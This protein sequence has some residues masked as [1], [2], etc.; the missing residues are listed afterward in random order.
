MRLLLP[1]VS[2]WS[3]FDYFSQPT[4]CCWQPCMRANCAQ[5][6]GKAP[7]GDH[8]GFLPW[9]LSPR[10]LPS[11][12]TEDTRKCIMILWPCNKECCCS[13][14]V[15]MPT[16]TDTRAYLRKHALYILHLAVAC[17]SD[18]RLDCSW[19]LTCSLCSVRSDFILGNM[20]WALERVH[21][22]GKEALHTVDLH[23]SVWPW[24]FS[25]SQL[26]APFAAWSTLPWISTF[27]PSIG[28]FHPGT[29]P[30]WSPSSL[31][32]V[33]SNRWKE[34]SPKKCIKGLWAQAQCKRWWRQ[35]RCDANLPL[36]HKAVKAQTFTISKKP[37][38]DASVTCRLDQT[39]KP[40]GWMDPHLTLSMN[41][42]HTITVS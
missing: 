15:H 41:A 2:V 39:D 40:R 23:I 42:F 37:R 1:A 18:R 34:K 28:A 36:T 19:P 12:T 10:L 33:Y 35:R 17:H 29:M 6:G 7:A 24:A 9:Y 14:P 22:W 11:F 26:S 32:A 31:H 16:D 30:G 13:Q 5:G 3:Q 8:F 20:R 38:E 25:P 21:G 4:H 27:L